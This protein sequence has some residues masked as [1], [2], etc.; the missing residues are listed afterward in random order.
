MS[1][2]SFASA[3][4]NNF[5]MVDNNFINNP[6]LTLEAKHLLTIFLSNS[7]D[8]KINMTDIVKRSKNGR[9]KHYACLRELITHG[10]VA[11]IEI[12]NG[13]NKRYEQQIYVFSDIV[14]EVK[15]QT[16]TIYKDYLQQ[17]KKV[18]I[19]HE[20]NKQ[21]SGTEKPFTENPDTGQKPFTENPDTE[22]PDTEK[23]HIN[24]KNLENKNYKKKNLNKDQSREDA[25]NS[26]DVPH[27]IKTTLTNYQKRLIDDDISLMD[28]ESNYK[29]HKELLTVGEYQSALN[30]VLAK[31]ERPIASI[32]AA[33]RTAITKKL[34]LREKANQSH[35]PQRDTMPKW[36]KDEED[37]A[38]INAD[39]LTPV[40]DHDDS[41][42][43][44][45]QARFQRM[46]EQ[47]RKQRSDH[48]AI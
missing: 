47:R 40:E 13:I 39:E 31:F 26:L 42:L 28:I 19:Y 24:N 2:T 43:E 46:L 33:M 32:E 9:D 11:R 16:D 25:I 37:T 36:F 1:T 29:A 12:H 22:K 17:G 41:N 5:T 23:P 34:E 10:Y 4:R 48:P 35:Q 8:W 14:E 44:E 3:K 27:E 7:E 15:A 45:A 38:A 30:F 6:Q 20:Q 18:T 21:K